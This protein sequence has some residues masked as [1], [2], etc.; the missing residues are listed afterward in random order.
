M[1]KDYIIIFSVAILAFGCSSEPP[2]LHE[3]LHGHWVKVRKMNGSEA[4]RSR[5]RY[6]SHDK[7]IYTQDPKDKLK[8]FSYSVVSSDEG[9]NR[10]KLKSIPE[11]SSGTD[12]YSELLIEFS[13]DRK[14]IKY[15]PTHDLGKFG[16]TTLGTSIW[17]FVDDKV[18]P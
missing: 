3:S 11:D 7:I 9:T 5:H 16:K 6:F 2:S 12:E 4:D 1:I 15:T 14:S 18:S 17:E 13:L 10:L 8:H